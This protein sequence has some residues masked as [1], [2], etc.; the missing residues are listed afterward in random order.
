MEWG[1]KTNDMPLSDNYRRL[2]ALIDALESHGV[3]VREALPIDGNG[4]D[5]SSEFTVHLSVDLSDAT[6]L[7]QFTG[8]DTGDSSV[9][10]TQDRSDSAVDVPESSADA[11]DPRPAA[12]DGERS[13][14]PAD[15][16]AESTDAA[17]DGD[18]D[19]G[20]LAGQ[21]RT[22]GDDSQSTAESTAG[23]EHD[24]VACTHPECDR[25][26]ETERGMK[27]HRTKAH[28][29]SEMA[30]E[31]APKHYDPDSLHAVYE[32][33]E[34]FDEMT[35]ALDVDVGPQAVRKQ[36]IR[37]GIHRPGGRDDGSEE[38]DEVDEAADGDDAESREEEQST[39]DASRDEDA[40]VDHA[41]EAEPGVAGDTNAAA[42]DEDEDA[43]ERVADR[44]PDLDLPGD[45]S[46]DELKTAVE[47]AN[48]LY[49]VQR[50]LDVDRG[51]ARDILSEYD[52][53]ELVTGRVASARDREEMKAEIHE[54]L[55]RAAT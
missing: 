2:A 40:D 54:R 23:T 5:P 19:G 13:G 43:D 26:F 28:P 41:D 51:T 44:L 8:D 31:R 50:T 20:E 42:A 55:R 30:S 12:D 25:T 29:L 9:P 48:T 14:G 3:D 11:D 49:D 22:G 32:E 52:L 7:G 10:T 16:T 34:T 35:A 27:I 53:L 21:P 18:A 6:S 38:T 36:M 17:T 39:D 33:Y 15:R 1:G 46:V 45:L 37:L 24:A 4:D 47:D